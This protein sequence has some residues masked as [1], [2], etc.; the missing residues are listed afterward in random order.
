VLWHNLH[1]K[2][3]E[4]PSL[5]LKVGEWGIMDMMIQ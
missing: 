2:F 4:S 1:I 3:H 5:G